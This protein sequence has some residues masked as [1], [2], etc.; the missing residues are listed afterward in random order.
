[1]KTIQPVKVWSNGQEQEATVLSAYASYDNLNNAATFSYQLM[2]EPPQVNNPI[3]G[4]F[5]VASGTLSMTGEVY[6]N[7][8]TNDYAYDWVAEQ[9]N[10]TIIGEYVPPSGTTT[11]TTT[12][13]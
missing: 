2:I 1:M 13:L 5:P 10:L 6:Q 7:W 8:E 11:T 3:T 4:L 12:T 9:L